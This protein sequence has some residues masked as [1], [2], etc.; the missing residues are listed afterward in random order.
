M[1]NWPPCIEYKYTMSW[2]DFICIK[3][4][5][6]FKYSFSGAVFRAQIDQI[7]SH[8]VLAIRD[9]Y[10][11]VYNVHCTLYSLQC[12]LYSLQCTLYSVH[13]YT[14]WI[15][16]YKWPENVTAMYEWSPCISVSGIFLWAIFV[17]LSTMTYLYFFLLNKNKVNVMKY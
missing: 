6:E 15:T 2:V 9:I 3:F 11:T 13:P 14:G 17:L 12:T 1:Y 16:F 5:I 7:I 4:I 10:C 8:V